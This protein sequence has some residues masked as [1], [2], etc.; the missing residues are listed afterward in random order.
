[1]AI[2]KTYT[3][4]PGDRISY[5]A[6]WEK[7]TSQQIINATPKVFTKKRI[8]ETNRLIADNTIPQGEVLLYVGDVLNIPDGEVDII[9]AEQIIKID[10]DDELTIF[11]DNKK[12]PPPSNFEFIEYFDACSHSFNIGNPFDATVSFPVYNIDF[13][14][15]KT[16]GLYPIKIYIGADPVLTGDIETIVNSVTPSQV[17]QTLAGRNKTYLLE[18]SDMLPSIQ[19][20]FLKLKLDKIIEILCS[21]HSIE[22][23][24]DSSVDIGEAF[25][26]VTVSDNDTPYSVISNL[27]RERSAIATNTGDSKLLITKLPVTNPVANFNIDAGFLK[28]IG[29]ENLNFTFDTTNI[30]GNYIGKAQ[31]PDDANLEEVVSSKILKQQSVK[32][33]TFQNAVSGNLKSLTEWEEQKT[34][35]EF[36][37]NEIPYPSWL[38]PNTNKRWK[39]GQ[40]ITIQGR[41]ALIPDPIKMMIKEIVFSSSGGGAKTA[42]LKL[43]PM[44]VYI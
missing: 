5:I 12:I 23:T 4:K 26:Q 40:I 25:P 28:F 19:R 22:Y 14:R 29:I 11:I 32:I 24:I 18:K 7:V 30:F 17:S 13:E 10:A 2:K 36:Y 42:T 41:D 9:S 1:M 38:N 27:A 33:F 39:V 21:P 37:N 6:T 3:V 43:L 34:I 44:E 8:A 15:F 31:T 16:K 35:R 20:E